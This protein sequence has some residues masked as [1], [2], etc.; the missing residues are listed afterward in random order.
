MKWFICLMIGLMIVISPAFAERQW[1]EIHDGLVVSTHDM[2]D[3]LIPKFN[4]NTFRYAVEVTDIN[5]QPIAQWK[6]DLVTGVFSVPDPV[7]V[8]TITSKALVQ[9]FTSAEREVFFNSV[10]T[11]VVMVKWWLA[12]SGDVNLTD[13]QVIAGIG[14]LETKGVLGVGRAAVVLTVE[15]Q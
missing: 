13:P 8:E 4:P 1:A 10:D 12:F 7:Y 6:Y 14:I 5:P 2:P 15:T 3:H 11:K 9:R